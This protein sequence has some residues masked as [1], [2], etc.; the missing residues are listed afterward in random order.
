MLILGLNGLQG[1]GVDYTGEAPPKKVTF[2]RLEVYQRVG[3]SQAEEN[4]R[5]GKT[6]N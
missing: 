5:V 4:K 3:I 2:F 1:K 6:V